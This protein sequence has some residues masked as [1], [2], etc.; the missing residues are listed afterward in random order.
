VLIEPILNFTGRPFVSR[1][2]LENTV[3]RLVR[4]VFD[5]HHA[6]LMAR[7]INATTL[8][9]QALVSYIHCFI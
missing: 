8:P 3:E 7:V 2:E 5:K 4:A 9:F 1:L 6:D